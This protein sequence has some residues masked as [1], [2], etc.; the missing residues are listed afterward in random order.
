MRPVGV[1][2]LTVLVLAQI[3]TQ[4]ELPERSCQSS[5]E[6]KVEMRMATERVQFI[7]G[8]S[9]FDTVHEVDA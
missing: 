8:Q 5:P 9:S 3:L 6:T 7:G 1:R 2:S 4:L